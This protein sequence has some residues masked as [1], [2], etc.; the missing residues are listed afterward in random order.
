MR[1]NSARG[2]RSAVVPHLLPTLGLLTGLLGLGC[3]PGGVGD[4]CVPEDEYR[5]D[6]SGFS[7]EEVNVESKSFQCLT[8]VCLVNHFQGRVSCPYGQSEATADACSENAGDCLPGSQSHRESCRIPGQDGTDVNDR[9]HVPVQPQKVDR[10]ANQA[11]Y[12]SCRCAGPDPNANYCECPSGFSCV[13]L[14]DDIGLGKGQLAGSYCVKNGTKYEGANTASG[15]DCN[16][17]AANCGSTVEVNGQ[18]IGANPPL[19]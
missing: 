5:T 19:D 10:Q 17:A 3:D 11:V 6:F 1:E 13:E 9:I 2:T 14:V 16:P 15:S 12:C 7:I 8:R 4:P 18:T